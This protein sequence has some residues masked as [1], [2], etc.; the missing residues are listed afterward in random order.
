MDSLDRHWSPQAQLVS[1]EHVTY[2]HVGRAERLAET[3]GL[4]ASR[5][6]VDVSTPPRENTALLP[7]SPE[8]FDDATLRASDPL[9]AP[10]REAFAYERLTAATE[11]P[12]AEWRAT[13]AASLG[14]IRAV[15]ERNERIGDLRR[16]LDDGPSEP[17]RLRRW[18]ARRS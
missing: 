12:P 15:I 13:V 4:L 7:F 2:D 18:T 16:L 3:Y 9:T 5:L 17:R 11:E 6:G 10:D 8:L 14:A 1:L